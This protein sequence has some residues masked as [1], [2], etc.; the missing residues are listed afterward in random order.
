MDHADRHRDRIRRGDRDPDRSGGRDRSGAMPTVGS[1]DELVGLLASGRGLYVRRPVGPDADLP[2]L[3]SR[4]ELT[5]AQLPGLSAGPLDAEPW[6]GDRP[7]RRWAARRLHDYAHLPRV[8]DG[9]VRPW[10]LRGSE[11]GRGPDNEPLVHEVEPIGWI[12]PRVVAE[13]DAE[14]TRQSRPWGPLDRHG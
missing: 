3:S 5:G 1:L 12:D 11:A 13:A 6:W 14:I 2:G 10:L 8:R 4:D 9:R 7:L